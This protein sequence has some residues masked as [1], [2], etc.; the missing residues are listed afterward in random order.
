MRRME[1]GSASY[2]QAN[3]VFNI[4]ILLSFTETRNWRKDLVGKVLSS[5][6]GVIFIDIGRPLDTVK[7]NCFSKVKAF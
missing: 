7:Y 5:S 1:K 4:Y 3:R 6:D 2:V